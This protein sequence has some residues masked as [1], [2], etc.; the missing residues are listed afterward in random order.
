MSEQT[1]AATVVRNAAQHRYEIWYGNTLAGFTEYRERDN[2]TT[3]IHTE[4]DKAFGGKGLGSALARQAVE[5]VIA[6][7]R[8]IV[9]RCPFI[10]AWLDKHPDYEEHVLGKGIKR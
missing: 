9:P 8:V 6:R 1:V 10:K 3:F 2:D 5:D 4:V 7:G